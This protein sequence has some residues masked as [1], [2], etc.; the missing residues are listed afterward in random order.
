MCKFGQ[1]FKQASKTSAV[2]LLDRY[3]N[4]LIFRYMWSDRRATRLVGVA[5]TSWVRGPRRKVVFGTI[6]ELRE[7]RMFD[8]QAPIERRSRLT[9]LLVI[10]SVLAILGVMTWYFTQ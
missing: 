9:M 8:T 2:H 3:Q 6:E 1:I 5:Q 7:V 10:A 4:E